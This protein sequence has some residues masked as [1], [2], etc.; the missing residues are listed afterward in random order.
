M[1]HARSRAEILAGLTAAATAAALP[2]P[3]GAADPVALR[4]GLIPIWDVAPYYAAEQQGY[5][6]AE[7]LAVTPQVVRGGAV[8]I[9]AMA[10]GT[11]DMVYSNGVSIVQAIARGIDLRIVIEG[12]PLGK[13]PP[14]PGALLK[15]K[16]DPLRTGTDLAGKVVG[17]NALRDIQWMFVRAWIKATG[18]EPDNVQMVELGL[19]AMIDTIKAKRVDA[20]LVLDPFLTIGLGDPEIELLDWPL[21]KVYPSGPTAFFVTTPQIVEKRAAEI[22]AFVRAYKRGVA[23]INGNAGK[24]AFVSL[25]ADFTK[26]S[27][28]LIRRIKAP[29]AN[30]DVFPNTLPMLTALMQQTGLLT[31][32]VDLR[33]K[34]FR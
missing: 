21:S 33:P 29:P 18:G 15:R 2:A 6:A 24:D 30:A 7:N 28:D 14:D 26:I 27:P 11:F 13:T 22:R 12:A 8:G 16:G 17:V 9:P 25:I 32:N 5:F 34:V 20:A 31:A 10:G 19:P 4:V 3:A 23:W 1:P